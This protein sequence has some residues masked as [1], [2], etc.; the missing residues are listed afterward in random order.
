[1]NSEKPAR[2]LS[3]LRIIIAVFVALL[4]L[5]A[6]IVAIMAATEAL[7]ARQ[8]PQSLTLPDGSRVEFLGTAAGNQ[9]F[10]S[11]T[12]WQQRLR[13]ILPASLQNR[14]LPP[15]FTVNSLFSSSSS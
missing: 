4:L 13:R 5:G 6:L 2:H 12:P 15:A 8:P 9:P 3:I 7:H 11:A 14:W 10:T 1:M